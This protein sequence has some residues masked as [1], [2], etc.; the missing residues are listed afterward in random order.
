[1]SYLTKFWYWLRGQYYI[2]TRSE[3][4]IKTYY[5]CG[6]NFQHDQRLKVYSS[7]DLLKQDR[8]C[9]GECGIVELK[10]VCAKWVEDQYILTDLFG[11]QK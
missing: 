4:K 11:E 5:T 1:M 8:D 3:H 2:L 7:A 10:L 9:Y 6:T